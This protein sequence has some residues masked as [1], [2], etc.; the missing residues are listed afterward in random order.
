MEFGLFIIATV[1]VYGL[2]WSIRSSKT[3]GEAAHGH[4]HGGH[5]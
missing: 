1:I 3:G 4:S 2:V 5:H